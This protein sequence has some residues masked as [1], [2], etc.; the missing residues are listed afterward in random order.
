M[1][2]Y[3]TLK[4]PNIG[5]LILVASPTHL[6][7]I[8][9]SGCDHV[10]TAKKEW[11]HDL[12]HPVLKKAS[13]ELLEYFRGERKSFSVPLHFDGTEFQNNVWKQ[14]ARIPFG[15]TITYTELA[16]RAGNPAALRAAGTATGRNPLAV[17]IPCHRVVGKNGGLGGFAG[18]L[19]R[20]RRLLAI[21]MD[22]AG[23]AN[24]MNN[25]RTKDE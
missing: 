4:T 23:K 24:A 18:G 14:I 5:D 2:S 20:K 25:S 7:G 17:I 3:T 9:F 12:H 11:A 1:T 6:I 22:K 16:E 15:K 10:P 8:Y 13:Q 19:D 21:E